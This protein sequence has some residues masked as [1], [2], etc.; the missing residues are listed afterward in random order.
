MSK[1]Q[2]TDPKLFPMWLHAVRRDRPGEEATVDWA[3]RLDEMS[4]LHHRGNAE[5][6]AEVKAEVA[7]LKAQIDELKELILQ[8]SLQKKK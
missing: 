5:V 4:E 1:A 3:G 6:K 2:R 7:G 8:Q